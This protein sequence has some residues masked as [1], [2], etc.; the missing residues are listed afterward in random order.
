MKNIGEVL[1]KP[2]MSSNL[3]HNR[4]TP[5]NLFFVLV[6]SKNKYKNIYFI[7]AIKAF[8]ISV[9]LYVKKW[10]KSIKKQGNSQ[11]IMKVRTYPIKINEEKMHLQN[12]FILP[13]THKSF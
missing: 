11:Q 1:S 2:K 10:F 5:E 4:K 12:Y 9:I 13:L 7:K 8:S 3:L 6:F